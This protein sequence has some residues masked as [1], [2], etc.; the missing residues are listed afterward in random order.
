MKKQTHDTN[1]DGTDGDGSLPSAWSDVINRT[2][3]A[4]VLKW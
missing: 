2:Q 4:A 1:P 3:T